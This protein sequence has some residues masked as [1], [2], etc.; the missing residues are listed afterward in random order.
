RFA[1]VHCRR[2]KMSVQVS[3][4]RARLANLGLGRLGTNA[5]FSRRL[6]R[7]NGWS[8]EHA[9]RVITEYERFLLL[10][11]TANELLSP[12]DAV[13][14]AWHLHLLHTRDYRRFCRNLFGRR[15]DHTPSAGGAEEQKKFEA[16]YV[17]VLERYRETFGEEPPVDIWP[18]L[19]VRQSTRT[20]FVRLDLRAHWG[21]PKPRFLRALSERLPESLSERKVF[22]ALAGAL[23]VGCATSHAAPWHISG[24]AFLR[25][26]V[27]GW[28]LCLAFALIAR[29]GLDIPWLHQT[30]GHP[31][32]DAYE[33]AYL[34]G[35]GEAA[36]DAAI[37]MLVA[38]GAASFD[39]EAGTLLA[40]A[41]IAPGAHFL[42]SQVHSALSPETP[43]EV[44]SIRAE[45]ENLS[46]PIRQRLSELGLI[47][48]PGSRLPRAIALA[49]PIVGVLR[50][51][52][53]IGTGRPVVILILL[54]IIGAVI[55]FV[56]FRRTLRTRS[57]E[58]LLREV[59]RRHLPLSESREMG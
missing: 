18:S 59:K 12:S 7:E 8:N 19:E 44:R 22:A 58:I 55:A 35:K 40:T 20:E 50:I 46:A 3:E 57:G 34:K 11:A 42:E 25:W 47:A 16:A 36:V 41:R 2:R 39:A 17:R 43:R 6:A 33:A 37:A 21:L 32:L 28:V 27:L 49:A 9:V 13:D 38:T 5:I 45:A 29:R 51:L 52:S 53:R 30:G 48:E 24:P 54:T 1:S 4:L 23:A 26:F 14:Q 31:D 10:V 15:L 56:A